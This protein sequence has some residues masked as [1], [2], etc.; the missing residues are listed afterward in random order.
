MP[1][2]E[3]HRANSGQMRKHAGRLDDAVPLN[4]QTDINASRTVVGC[5]D[6]QAPRPARRT[7]F[8]WR[9]RH[10]RHH[11]VRDMRF[12][13]PFFVEPSEETSWSEEQLIILKKQ[14]KKS[15]EHPK[16]AAMED[17]EGE[18]YLN[19]VGNRTT[20]QLES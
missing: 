14:S 15:Q 18:Q 10:E 11:D 9:Q 3:L 19:R 2:G 6:L 17:Q 8:C 12:L 7:G 4:E 16:S 5:C 13:L 20:E 1:R